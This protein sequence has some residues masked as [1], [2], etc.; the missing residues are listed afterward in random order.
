MVR[1]AFKDGELPVGKSA[2]N[3]LS[4]GVA[5]GRDDVKSPFGRALVRRDWLMGILLI[6]SKT[7]V[8]KL[9][10]CE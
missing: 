6:N 1:S 9:F 4:G 7:G 2:G 3:L 10:L 8:V 5:P